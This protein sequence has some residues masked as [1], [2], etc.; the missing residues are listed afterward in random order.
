MAEKDPLFGNKLAFSG[1]AALLLIFGLPQV[2]DALFGGGHGGGHGGEDVHLAYAVEYEDAGSAEQTAAPVVD[3]GA[4]MAAV[5]P[6]AAASRAGLCKSCHTFE[7][8]GATLQGPNLWGIVDRPVASLD[9]FAYSAAIKAA[10]GVWSYDRI[11]ALIENSQAFIPGTSMN[12]RVAKAEH[13]AQI[14]VYLSTLSDAPVPFPAPAD[15][16]PADSA[17]VDPA[18]TP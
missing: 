8:G 10:G 6:G 4:L 16:A 11:N 9:G 3:L 18:A 14:L 17:P 5:N 1:L 15:A 12:Q 2:T 7:K 13:R